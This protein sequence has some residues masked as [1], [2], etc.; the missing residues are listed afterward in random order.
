[1]A[2][3]D[4]PAAWRPKQFELSLFRATVQSRSPT[5]QAFHAVDLLAWRW[6]VAL[7]MGDELTADAGPYEAFFNRLS[8]GVNDVRLWHFNRPVPLG[9]MRGAPTLASAAA[10]FTDVLSVQTVAGATL[11]DGDFLGLANQLLQVA[12]PATANGSGV[13]TVRL[14]NRLRAAV[15]TSTAVLWDKPTARFV[16]PASQAR[17]GHVGGRML[18][19]GFDLEEVF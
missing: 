9:T 18:G 8:G 6:M 16:V 5:T 7:E 2:T 17:F 11:L 13:M 15:A 10:Q 1:M 3:F 14:V 4:W 12:E 19:A